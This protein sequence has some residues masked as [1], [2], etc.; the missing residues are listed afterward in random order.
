MLPQPVRWAAGGISNTIGGFIKN[1]NP[2]KEQA[3]LADSTHEEGH[4]GGGDVSQVSF[5]AVHRSLSDLPKASKAPLSPFPF[6]RPRPRPGNCSKSPP[7]PAPPRPSPETVVNLG[8]G[9]WQA[10]C[11]PPME[12]VEKIRLITSHLAGKVRTVDH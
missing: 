3:S 8:K 10:S 1:F 7:R 5:S 12:K 4:D 9:I 2:W 6:P 11:E